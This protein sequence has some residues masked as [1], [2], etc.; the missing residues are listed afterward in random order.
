MDWIT[1]LGFSAGSITSLGF[2][3]QVIKTFRTRHVDDLALFMPVLLAV[4]MSLWLFYG[5]IRRD[6]AIIAANIFG[7]VC[8][9]YLVFAKIKYSKSS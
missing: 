8:T 7:V 5:I 9:S 6:W 1:L 4:G 2:L 3:P